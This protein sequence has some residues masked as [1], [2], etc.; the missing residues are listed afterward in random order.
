MSSPVNAANNDI[1][2]DNTNN[3]NITNVDITNTENVEVN[4]ENVEVNTENVD[5]TNTENVE[6]NTENA[7]VK[8]KKQKKT[9]KRKKTQ[10]AKEADYLTEDPIMEDQQFT[11]VSFL[12][13]SS[14][15]EATRDKTLTVSGFKVR[16]SYSTIEEA[17]KRC[18]FLTKC[19]PFHNIYVASVGKWCPYEDDPEKAKNNE[20]MN[21][22]LNKLMKSYIEQQSEAKEFHEIRKQ[23]MIKKAME[24]AQ[25]I[26]ENPATPVVLPTDSNIPTETSDPIES[27]IKTKRRKTI[28][29]IKTE[30]EEN[31]NELENN[32][33]NIDDSLDK[34]KKLEDEF[35]EKM[36]ELES[37]Q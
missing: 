24:E 30:V 35:N 31:K 9:T 2:D 25:K 19:D 4:T 27:K 6:V 18:D 5:I 1:P 29:K 8:I 3:P 22:D 7:E 10:A 20:Y 13:T 11:C 28:K 37:K 36:K 32:K 33:K 21:K 17:Q 16:G 15:N 14:I 26:K 34:L 23:D 12:K